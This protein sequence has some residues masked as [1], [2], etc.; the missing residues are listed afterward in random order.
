MAAVS[1]QWLKIWDSITME[2]RKR[3]GNNKPSLP[4]LLSPLLNQTKNRASLAQLSVTCYHGPRR[5]RLQTAWKPENRGCLQCL[6]RNGPGEKV[7]ILG[8]SKRGQLV[9]GRAEKPDNLEIS[10]H[11]KLFHSQAGNEQ[12]GAQ[13]QGPTIGSQNYGRWC[14]VGP[15]TTE[16]TGGWRRCC[17]SWRC[18]GGGV[19][20]TATLA[21]P[22]FPPSVSLSHWPKLGGSLL[23]GGS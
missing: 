10:D 1:S 23:E 14:P 3:S 21:F 9:Q 11:R 22:L 6:C 18:H 5:Q 15:G 13:S 16:G 4:C 2:N 20:G 7:A 17:C 19:R 8:I 12:G